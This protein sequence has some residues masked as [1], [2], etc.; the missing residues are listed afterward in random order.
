MTTPPDP[1]AG[2]YPQGSY[3]P[4]GSYPPAAPQPG[5]GQPQYGQQQYGQPQYGPPAA[6]GQPGQAQPYGA[7][8][9]GVLTAAAVL[10]FVGG[11]FG[12]IGNLSNF[13][14]FSFISGFLV[15]LS[16]L[17]LVAAAGLIFG[18]IQAITGKDTRI[19]IGAAA[20]LIG[21]NLIVL[22]WVMSQWG[23][24]GVGLISFVLPILVI[25][26][27]RNPQS[28]AWIRSKGGTTL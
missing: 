6:Y 27:A 19:L 20:A 8:R 18:G 10:A 28:T 24:Y 11:G 17:S 23:F 25:V 22:I 21:I 9:P 15:V 26:F 2:Q 13:S 4:P 3:P 14:V 1:N 7:K 5:P 12:L 16:I